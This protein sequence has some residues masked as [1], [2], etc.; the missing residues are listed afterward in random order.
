MG[1]CCGPRCGLGSQQESKR[2]KQRADVVLCGDGEEGVEALVEAFGVLLP[3]LVLQEDAHGV[4]AD[5]FAEAEFVVVERGVEG[6]GLE[7][8]E[9]VDGVGG[10]EVGADEP[11]LLC[12]PGVGCFFGPALGLLCE[13][14]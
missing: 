14:L 11:G 2:T 7:H 6:G 5:G 12:V 9:L 1:G 8:L 13:R 3:E 10:D 4:H